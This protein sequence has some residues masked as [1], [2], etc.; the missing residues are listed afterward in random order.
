MERWEICLGGTFSPLHKGHLRLFETAFSLGRVV[1]V[2]LTTD[3]FASLGRSRKVTPYDVRERDLRNE[4][5]D[6]S[7]VH[8]V[9]YTIGPITDRVGF[10]HEPRI[11]AIVVS[12]QTERYVDMIDEVRAKEGLSPL[13]RFVV[14]MV[15]DDMGNVLS[16][17][18]VQNG[19]VDASGRSAKERSGGGA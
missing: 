11:E 1:R 14:E 12:K 16:S 2:G 18:R 17:T 3:D 4:L 5:D 8:G 13:R 9:P 6:L 15:L 10:A 7:E 19:T